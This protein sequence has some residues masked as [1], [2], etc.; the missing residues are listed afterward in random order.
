L[1]LVIAEKLPVKN[2]R[3]NKTVKEVKRKKVI[4]D[5][6]TM[7]IQNLLEMSKRKIKMLIN[8]TSK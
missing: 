8:V 1:H 3:R 7:S 5:F 4:S 6:K 2:F